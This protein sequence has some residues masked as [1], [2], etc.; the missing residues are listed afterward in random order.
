[1]Q[2]RHFLRSA[3]FAAAALSSGAAFAR[4][5]DAPAA[6]NDARIADIPK[7]DFAP[8][9]PLAPIRA[10]ADRIVALNVCTRPFRAQGPRIEAERVGRHTIVHHYG[11]G[12]SGW[13]LSWGSAEQALRLVAAARPRRDELAVVGCG[14]IGL[15]TAVAAQHAGYRVRIYAKA[16]LPE[17]RS[18]LATGVWSPGSRICTAQFATPE[19]ERRWEAMARASFHTYQTLLGLPGEPVE[20]RDGYSLSDV[21]F[22]QPAG[23]GGHDDEPDYPRLEG[24]LLRDIDPRT[25][26]LAP[27]QHPFPVPYVR[28]YTQMTFNISAYSRMLMADFERAGGRFETRA[29]E[30]LRE[31]ASLDERVVVNCTGY[32]AR[33]LLGDDSVVPV[34]G[35]TARLVPQP[36]VTYGLN[37]RGHNLYTVPRRDGI[38][39]QAQAPGDFGNP[40]TTPDRAA[41]KAVVAR[42]ASLFPQA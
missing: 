22:D 26:A 2:R 24:R 17:V 41:A 14:A 25:V 16:R 10:S 35:Q 11:H 39:V 7:P 9:P 38:L 20:W 5:D 40:D 23:G 31:L 21:P 19:F 30:S 27:S 6:A 3:G 4:G 37:W 36:E 42:L 33:A 1:M 13:S 34:R 29:F 28:R 15:T 8:P 32:G 12:G 18:F